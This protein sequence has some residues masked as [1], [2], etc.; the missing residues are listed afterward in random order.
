MHERHSVHEMNFG[1][2]TCETYASSHTNGPVFFP[3][4]ILA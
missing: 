4:H 2:E 3:V 1:C